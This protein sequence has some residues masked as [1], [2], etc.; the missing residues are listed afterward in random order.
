MFTA[1]TEYDLTI[2][3]IVTG[4]M[5]YHITFGEYATQNDTQVTMP[6]EGLWYSSGLPSPLDDFQVFSDADGGLGIKAAKEGESLTSLHL[7][8]SSN[9]SN[10]NFIAMQIFLSEHISAHP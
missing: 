9:I 10:T 2:Q 7:C 8:Y 1:K 4:K 5:K 3:D 6:E